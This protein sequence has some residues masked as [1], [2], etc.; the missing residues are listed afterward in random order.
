MVSEVS[1]AV[2][3]V[4]SSFCIVSDS[5]EEEVFAVSVSLLSSL[6]L[7]VS[8]DFEGVPHCVQTAEIVKKK[9]IRRTDKTK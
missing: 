8:V 6:V 9:T 3:F 5:D 4:C 1:F 2:W 7:S